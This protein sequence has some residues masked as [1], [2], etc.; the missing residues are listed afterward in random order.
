VNDLS[1]KRELSH[2]FG[3]ALNAAV[4]LVVTPV[5][6]AL[7][8]WGR[9]SW[10]GTTPLF[11]VVLAAFTLGYVVWKQLRIYSGAMDQHQQDLLG[12]ADRGGRS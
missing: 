12:P 7:I 9:D 11:I 10:L 3:N 1:A 6:M 4:E 8:G 2:G 5:L